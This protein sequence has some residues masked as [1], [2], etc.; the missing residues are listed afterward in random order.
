M[1]ILKG[2]FC[3]N[4]HEFNRVL[5]RLSASHLQLFRF[6]PESSAISPNFSGDLR[7]WLTFFVTLS[8]SVAFGFFHLPQGLARPARLK[9][10]GEPRFPLKPLP[11]GGTLGF[12]ALTSFAVHFQAETIRG[13]RI[14]VV[15]T[16]TPMPFS[17]SVFFE[18]LDLIFQSGDLFR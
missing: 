13:W 4:H 2:D 3:W 1:L 14:F 15:E 8:Q 12:C 5:M 16:K 9:R 6:Q 10:E 17:V 7:F 18:S 11:L